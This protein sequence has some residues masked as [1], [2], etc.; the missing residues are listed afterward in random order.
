MRVYQILNNMVFR[1]NRT[2]LAL[3][4]FTDKVLKA[5]NNG[6][7]VLGIFSDFSKAF[8][9]IGPQNSCIKTKECKL[10]KY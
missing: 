9:T 3:V 1:K 6:K 5:M 10:F 8:D 2:C 4:K 7:S